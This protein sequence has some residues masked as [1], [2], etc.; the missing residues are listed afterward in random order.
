M[1]ADSGKNELFSFFKTV[2]LA[3]LI[4]AFVSSALVF[5]PAGVRSACNLFG[6]ALLSLGLLFA[7]LKTAQA[8]FAANRRS[9]ALGL[10]WLAKI[11]LTALVLFLLDR[12]KLL[13]VPYLL[14]GYSLHL[15]LL[16]VAGWKSALA[17]QARSKV[18]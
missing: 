16:V 4:A 1:Y 11:A 3:T 18:H 15:P 6:G 9:F 13:A 2:A 8:F 12:Y 17:L 14:A 10:R 7:T 5:R